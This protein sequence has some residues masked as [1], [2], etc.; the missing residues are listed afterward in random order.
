MGVFVVNNNYSLIFFQLIFYNTEKSNLLCWKKQLL[1][2]PMMSNLCFTISRK[3][4]RRA[5]ESIV[6]TRATPTS[7][8]VSTTSAF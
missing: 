1:R 7:L 5:L 4:P 2:K 3:R 8:L 6:V